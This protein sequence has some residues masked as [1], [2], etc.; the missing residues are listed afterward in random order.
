MLPFVRSSFDF[1]SVRSSFAFSLSYNVIVGAVF[2]RNICSS[3]RLSLLRCNNAAVKLAMEVR[4]ADSSTA[5][6]YNDMKRSHT[7]DMVSGK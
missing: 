3:E 7:A 4:G 6:D 1:P 2:E 5:T